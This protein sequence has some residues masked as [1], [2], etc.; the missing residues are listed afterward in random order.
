MKIEK[1]SKIQLQTSK[2]KDKKPAQDKAKDQKKP[3]EQVKTEQTK[4]TTDK[5]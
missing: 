3:A 4:K 2:T 1:L 5:K